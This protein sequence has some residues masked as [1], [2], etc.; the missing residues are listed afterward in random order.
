MVHQ[1]IECP[2][3]TP[4]I[5]DARCSFYKGLFQETLPGFIKDNPLLEKPKVIHLDADLFSATLYVLTMLHPYLNKGDILIFDEF[6]VPLHEFKAFDD[7]VTSFYVD[8]EVLGA[9]NNYYQVALR[10][11]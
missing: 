11:Q 6:N 1:R 10:I 9:T 8:Y 3:A 7:Y 5:E 2:A 4:N